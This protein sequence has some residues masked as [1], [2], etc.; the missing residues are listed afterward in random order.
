M[1]TR[2]RGRSPALQLPP[3][4]AAIQA[5]G[6]RRDSR[7]PQHTPRGPSRTPGVPPRTPEVLP[8]ALGVPPAPAGS[9]RL[10]PRSR[11]VGGSAAAGRFR[12]LDRGGAAASRASPG[13]VPPRRRGGDPP[14]AGPILAPLPLF[15]TLPGL[16]SSPAGAAEPR[17][18]AV[19]TGRGLAMGRS[20]PQRKRTRL[21]GET[22]LRGR[23]G[24]FRSCFNE[25]RA[26]RPAPA[27]LH[28]I[29]GRCRCW[30]R[31]GRPAVPRRQNGVA[32]PRGRP[33]RSQRQRAGP[34]FRN[35]ALFRYPPL[36][37]PPP[38]PRPAPEPE[39]LRA[40]AVPGAGGTKRDRPRTQRTGPGSTEPGRVPRPR[41]ALAVNSA[42]RGKL[43]PAAQGG[44]RRNRAR[45][46]AARGR[47]LVRAGAGAA[48]AAAG[49]RVSINRFFRL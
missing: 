49:L 31:C 29:R 1:E 46:H 20:P 13:H 23:K 38:R 25:H 30:G 16:G 43:C 44:P 24:S 28:R 40:R 21:C 4:L 39:L 12:T 8:H 35:T 2:R 14:R 42:E 26:V 9:R 7:L 10:P 15:P 32:K 18:R 36:L 37:P 48:P 47:G 11:P 19:G 22:L 6:S 27:A 17:G 41:I 33:A 45:G 34:A 5:T 3:R